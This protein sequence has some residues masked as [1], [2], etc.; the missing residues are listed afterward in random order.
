MGLK[1]FDI[2]T[3][4]G[5]RVSW[6]LHRGNRYRTGSLA[7]T[8]LS[9]IN[10]KQNIPE[11]FKVGVNYPNP[12]N[13]STSIDIET[14]K[15]N[16]LIVSVYDISGRLIN[17]LMNDKVDPGYYRVTWNGQSHLGQLMST[18]I[19]FF[20]IQSGADLRIKKIMLI[21]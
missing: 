16:K 17:T 13:P 7:M 6:K 10:E 9:T 11:I 14:A 5:N 15:S 12:F 4:S 1:I 2:K 20:Q 8:L 18:G 19:Y 21:K 3:E